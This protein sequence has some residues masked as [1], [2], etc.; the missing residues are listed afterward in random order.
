V[1]TGDLASP[2]GILGRLPAT[3]TQLR[4]WHDPTGCSPYLLA[5]CSQADESAV[6]RNQGCA[7][8]NLSRAIGTTGKLEGCGSDWS[9][10]PAL[11]TDFAGTPASAEGLTDS[12]DRG[13]HPPQ[14]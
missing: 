12:S 1:P 11:W 8:T 10:P 13:R 6:R 2:A 5:I 14:P 7:A 4:P 9:L 3:N